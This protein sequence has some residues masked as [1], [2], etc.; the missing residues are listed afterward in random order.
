MMNN[1]FDFL[2]VIDWL[3]TPLME[4]GAEIAL[5]K[6]SQ[7]KQIFILIIDDYLKSE[8]FNKRLPNILSSYDI[9]KKLE[10]IILSRNIKK[11]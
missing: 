11:L 2:I 10:R 8:G 3:V 6:A 4:I 5:E 7:D 9:P 1:K